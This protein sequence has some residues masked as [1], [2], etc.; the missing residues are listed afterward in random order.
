MRRGS[1]LSLFLLGCEVGGNAWPLEVQISRGLVNAMTQYGPSRCAERETELLA[2]PEGTFPAS[3]ILLTKSGDWVHVKLPA[4][5]R[6]I[7]VD[8]PPN[9]SRQFAL[10]LREGLGCDEVAV[11]PFSDGARAVVFADAGVFAVDPRSHRAALL[12]PRAATFESC[13]MS[14]GRTTM[15]CGLDL[16][17]GSATIHP[18]GRVERDEGW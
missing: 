12:D 6:W 15:R 4:G 8:A 5:P 14:S 9:V 17:F 16:T 18:D 3:D 10:G 13:A 11:V 7:N 1:L 2:V